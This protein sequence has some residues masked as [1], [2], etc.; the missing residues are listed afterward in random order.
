MCSWRMSAMVR[1]YAF[2]PP[3]CTNAV[4]RDG[5]QFWRYVR[6]SQQASPSMKSAPRSAPGRG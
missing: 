6:D 5:G 2:H 4:S 1:R 3:A